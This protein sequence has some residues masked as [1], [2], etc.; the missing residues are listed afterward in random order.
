MKK[1]RRIYILLII[2]FIIIIINTIL[3][4]NSNISN[5]AFKHLNP[6]KVSVF[7]YN[8]ND[9]YLAAVK[10]SL[11]KIQDENQDEIQFTFYDGKG[12][13]SIQSRQ[14]DEAI[15]EGTDMLFLNLVSVDS[16]QQVINRI[17][18][19]NL[20]VVLFNREPFTPSPIQSYSKAFYIGANEEEAGILQ[21]KI[22]IE[23]WNER[24]DSIDRNRDNIMQYIMLMGERDTRAAMERTRYSIETIE[25]SGIKTEELALR[26][27]DWNKEI[28]QKATEALLFRYRDT[29]EVII[30]NDD[31]MAEGAIR[32]LQEFGFNREEG[33]PM[34]PVVG[35][36]ATP[37]ARELIEKGVM[38]GTVLQDDYDMAEALYKVGMNLVQGN[39]PLKGTDY[40]ID[41]TWVAIRLPYS[42]YIKN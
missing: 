17:K 5:K 9:D 3:G 24:K 19:N 8:F 4:E 13:Q 36:N 16:A 14:I 18:E 21:G 28:A 41:G 31:A 39:N 2:V 7:L 42:E 30:A 35:V 12:E 10:E 27:A 29:I 33:G 37:E 22:I 15:N 6:V 34:I 11:E 1:N 20:P 32:A 38:T 25:K 23:E 26:V 40:V